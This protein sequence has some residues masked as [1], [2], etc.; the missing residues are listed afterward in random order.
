MTRTHKQ[1]RLLKP[2]N[3]AAEMCTI[4]RKHLKLIA[5]DAAH[6]AR[7]VYGFSIGWHDQGIAE[8][9]HSRLSLRK[10]ADVSQAYPRKIAIPATT[11][12]GGKKKTRNRH[13]QHDRS[14]AVEQDSQLHEESASR[15][16]SV[17]GR[18]CHRV[19]CTLIFSDYLSA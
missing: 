5:R 6:P 13:G 16:A 10:V 14:E 17:G 1:T 11:S 12:D 2:A 3:W 18:D 19:R 8:S 4:D 15:K 9:S 7:C